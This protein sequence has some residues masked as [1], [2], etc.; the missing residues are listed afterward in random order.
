MSNGVHF[1][2]IFSLIEVKLTDF[3]LFSII[4]ISYVKSTYLEKI[5]RLAPHYLMEKFSGIVPY[6]PEDNFLDGTC[7]V[8]IEF[9]PFHGERPGLSVY[10][11][12]KKAWKHIAKID[13]IF[14]IIIDRQTVKLE[15]RDCPAGFSIVIN[16]QPKRE[17][18]VSCLATYYR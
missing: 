16:D 15:I 17:S 18:F 2:K 10:Y 4:Y 9:L 8:D 11:P 12:Y 3:F 1:V 6:L 14:A 5:N 7:T 13:D